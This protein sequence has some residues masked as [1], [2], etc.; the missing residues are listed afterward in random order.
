MVLYTLGY[1]I[2][3]GHQYWN[4]FK[5]EAYAKNVLKNFFSEIV[6]PFKKEVFLR[7]SSTNFLF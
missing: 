4:F 7:K 1:G 5:I 3:D 6:E 2:Q